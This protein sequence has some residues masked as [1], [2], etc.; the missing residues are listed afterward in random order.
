M[1]RALFQTLVIL[2][3]LGS[4][5]T[6]ACTVID[7]KE[8]INLPAPTVITVTRNSIPSS[9]TAHSS[10]LA[11]TQQ[12]TTTPL[13]TRLVEQDVTPTNDHSVF[14]TLTAT[15]MSTSLPILTEE[16][17]YRVAFVAAN[18]VLNVRSGPGIE[19]QILGSLAP[20][21]TNIR[22]TTGGRQPVSGSTWV[23]I[24]KDET[25][26][27]VNG[28]YLTGYIPSTL[29]C[30]DPAVSDLLTQLN[31]A[32]ANEDSALLAQIIHPERGLRLHTSWWNPEVRLSGSDASNLFEST[33]SHE[34]GIEDGSGLP[35]VG[36]F[37]EV[38]LPLVQKDLLGAEI[39]R[40]NQPEYGPTAGSTQ[41]PDGYQSVN[42]N[43]FH[44]AAKDE[45]GFD[46]GTWI[47][48]I[49][50]WQSRYYLSFLVHYGYEI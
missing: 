33:V 46:W 30:Q 49:E 26:G 47:V 8:P 13:S 38:I 16:E 48:G 43:S 10:T 41:L 20:D 6:T 18:D 34:W 4:S 32:M 31:T 50:K 7:T 14:P 5:L 37:R 9:P 29:F 1:K 15:A 28:R 2:F 39:P 42:H 23:P 19:N 45:L 44:R 3:G 12:P 35:I 36:T 11:P 22:I 24:I 27:W 25:M 40:C 21:A 17:T